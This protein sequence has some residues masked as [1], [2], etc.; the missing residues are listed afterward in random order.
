MMAVV[1]LPVSAF[2]MPLWIQGV[3]VVG[4][5]LVSAALSGWL[6]QRPKIQKYV[7]ALAIAFL[8]ATA[9]GGAVKAHRGTLTVAPIIN[10]DYFW[11][12]LECWLL[13]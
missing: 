3:L 7:T 12:T 8:L 13:S 2:V 1:M 9:I 11:W 6:K 4:G 5:L 10:C